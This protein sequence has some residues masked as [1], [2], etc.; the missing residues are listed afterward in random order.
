MP[1]RFLTCDTQD[2]SYAKAAALGAATGYLA[3]RVLPLS[4]Q[5]Q[6]V[7][8]SAKNL[9]SQAKAGA[10]ESAQ[11]A[12]KNARPA[13]NYIVVGALAMMSALT[14]ANSAK[15]ISDINNRKANLDINA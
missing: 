15:K 3:K 6:R 8:D 10:L 13:L 14:I 11:N 5:E 7:L 4:G 1:V 12:I 9:S 2:V